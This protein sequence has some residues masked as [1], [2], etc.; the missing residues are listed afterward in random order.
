MAV[1]ANTIQTYDNP[2]LRE[3]LADTYSMIDPEKRPFLTAIGTADSAEQPFHEW[4]VMQ[5]QEV[6]QNNR[7]IEGDD[8]PP[9]DPGDHPQRIGNY[10]QISDKRV[11][12]SHT[13]EAS[14]A[15]VG[16]IHKLA[17]QILLKMR[18]LK[19]DQEAMLLMNVAANPGSEG[20]ARVAAGLPAFLMTNTLAGAGGVDP[21]L[22]GGTTGYPVTPA[23]PGT[24]RQL[25]EDLFSEAIQMAWETG[26]N[27]TLALV[28]SG[29]KRLISRTFTGN[30]TRYKDTSDRAVVAAIDVY[31]SDFGEKSIVPVHIMP[32]LNSDGADDA[33]WIPIIDP[34]FLG[35]SYL[36]TTRQKD[37]A[38]TGHSKDKLVWNEYTLQVDNEKAH[39]IIRDLTNG[40]AVTP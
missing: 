15:E 37:L 14:S 2:V 3:D 40:T 35:V 26:A 32:T 24:L 28:R 20:V 12:A 4:T 5:L 8:A 39:A 9:V 21:T 19:R 30:S 31:D 22:S 33:H 13:S 10:T 17:K 23:I 36:E 6:D 11:K 7:V 34:E 16:N 38:E 1:N 27:P 29:N 18:A 25:T